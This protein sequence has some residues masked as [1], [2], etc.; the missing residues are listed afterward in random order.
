MAEKLENET[1]RRTALE[2]LVKDMQESW[3]KQ[4]DLFN[5]KVKD[6]QE[7]NEG[8][9]PYEWMIESN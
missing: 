4:K 6:L 3:S 2:N 7:S 5:L 9:S 8:K 1:K